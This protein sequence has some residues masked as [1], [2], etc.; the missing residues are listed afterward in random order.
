MLIICP[1]CET[2][3]DVSAASL[4]DGGRTVRCVRC[5]KTWFATPPAEPSPESFAT[6]SAAAS[7]YQQGAT[8]AAAEGPPAETAADDDW[9]AAAAQEDEA[10]ANLA[11]RAAERGHATFDAPSPLEEALASFDAP[12]LAPAADEPPPASSPKDPHDIESIAARRARRQKYNPPPREIR[13]G[14][15]LLLGLLIAANG[16]ILGWRH[17]IVRSMPQTARLFAAIGL[18][19]N[20][21][22][23]DFVDVTTTK[24]THEGVTVLVVN[25]TIANPTGEPHEVP[26]VRFALKNP[27][28]NEVYSWTTLPGRGSLGAGES[29]PF[30]TRLASPPA[31][32]RDVVVRFFTR[33]DVAAGGH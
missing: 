3:Y 5:K 25:G 11:A 27:A 24:E 17:D 28:G 23:V 14:I 20:L 13:P 31:D 18:P 32:G 7:A 30:N 29:E 21:R 1:N 2:S 4:G 8:A 26:R 19:V 22:G 10:D 9:A 16:A 12:P 15:T 6:A 33:R